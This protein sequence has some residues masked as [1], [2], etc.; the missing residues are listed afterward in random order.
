MKPENFISDFK[1]IPL[2]EL[3]S[4]AATQE[5]ELKALVSIEKKFPFKRISFKNAISTGNGVN[6]ISTGNEANKVVPPTA[7]PLQVIP[8]ST[9]VDTRLCPSSIPIS[10]SQDTVPLEIRRRF[11]LTPTEVFE[12]AHNAIVRLTGRPRLLLTPAQRTIVN[13]LNE[14]I[15]IN[16]AHQNA[17]QQTR[18]MLA[19]ELDDLAAIADEA[20]DRIMNKLKNDTDTITE[21]N[22][23]N[24]NIELAER[25][26]NHQRSSI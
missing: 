7:E 21:T 1:S 8:V 9:T 19:P 5:E 12:S 16:R 2:K 24:H 25:Q 26:R 4:V 3:A 18:Q 22:I 6:V 17:F 23:S 13:V 10:V 11:Q 20:S 15:E 14:G